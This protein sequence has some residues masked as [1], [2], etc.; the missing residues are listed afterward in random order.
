MHSIKHF[1]YVNCSVTE[2]HTK[3]K[4]IKITKSLI[5]FMSHSIDDTKHRHGIMPK[6][7]SW[8]SVGRGGHVNMQ[9][10]Y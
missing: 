10:P 9:N 4:I 5:R 3:L 7:T 1:K 8:Y 6:P 2:N